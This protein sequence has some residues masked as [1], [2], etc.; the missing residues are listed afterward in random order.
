MRADYGDLDWRKAV[1]GKYFDAH[2]RHRNLVVLEPAVAAAF[3]NSAAVN[4]ALK[5]LMKARTER[6]NRATGRR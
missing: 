2:R 6:V 5:K 4:K 1:R 3:P